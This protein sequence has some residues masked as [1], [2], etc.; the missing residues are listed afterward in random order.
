MFNLSE[1]CKS[2]VEVFYLHVSD[3]DSRETSLEIALNILNN[4][5]L[6]R[7]GTAWIG[8]KPIGKFV[9]EWKQWGGVLFD[10]GKAKI[11]RFSNSK[12]F[13]NVKK[14]WKI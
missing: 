11:S 1:T 10:I 3:Y 5:I 9:D 12:I 7:E 4:I 2:K 13:K 6:N 8:E 14:Q